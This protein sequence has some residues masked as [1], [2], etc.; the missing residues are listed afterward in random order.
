M[1]YKSGWHRN[2]HWKQKDS[3]QHDGN[4]N[5]NQFEK[6]GQSHQQFDRTDRKN[7]LVVGNPV[8]IPADINEND[9]RLIKEI[10]YPDGFETA[11]RIV[12]IKDSE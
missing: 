11:F 7:T 5:R 4:T 2:D 10:K 3:T 1:W 6:S 8:G 9:F 12:E